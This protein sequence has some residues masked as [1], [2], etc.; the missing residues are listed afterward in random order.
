MSC[1]EE[2]AHA[3]LERWQRTLG[4][5]LTDALIG[6]I[7][8]YQKAVI[9]HGGQEM[10]DFNLLIVDL[11]KAADVRNAICHGSW[12]PPDAFGA[13]RLNF[14]NNKLNIFDTPVDIA[15]LQQL[16]KHVADLIVRVVNTVTTMG[17]QFPGSSGPGKPI[18]EIYEG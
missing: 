15:F 11:K 4:K 7:T 6:L 3:A 1:S 12:G 14:V 13:S 10:K 8:A 9:D 5:A 18:W 2:E 17:W 16:Q